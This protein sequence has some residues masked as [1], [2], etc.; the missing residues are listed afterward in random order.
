M[1]TLQ[2]AITIARYVTNDTNATS[3]SRTDAE[4]LQYANDA[5]DAIA[6]PKGRPDLFHTEVEIA[7][8]ANT[9]SQTLSVADSLGLVKIRHVKNGNAVTAIPAD[10]LDRFL[11]GWNAMTP[12]AAEHW[13]PDTSDAFRF[14]IYP[15]APT[16]QVLIGIHVAKP[17]EY[18]ASATHTLPDSFTPIIADYIVARLDSK[19]DEHA[20]NGRAKM[21]MDSFYARLGKAAPQN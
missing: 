11:P 20:V 15:P 7:C 2:Q 12:A 13:I 6:S 8:I 3:Y 19:E 1:A 5:L 9:T 10:T 21:Y 4:L 18:T 14:R 16:G 17:L